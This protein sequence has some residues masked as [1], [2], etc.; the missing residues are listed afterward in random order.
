ME[1]SFTAGHI[2]P[3]LIVYN[4]SIALFAMPPSIQRKRGDPFK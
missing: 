4:A 3:N 1:I 2:L